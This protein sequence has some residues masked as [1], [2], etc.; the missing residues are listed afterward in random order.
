ME[1]TNVL[2]QKSGKTA[3]VVILLLVIAVGGFYYWWNNKIKDTNL[4]QQTGIGGEEDV[5]SLTPTLPEISFKKPMEVKT[6]EN[7][8]LSFSL[9]YESELGTLE[10]G[11]E[12][13]VY[14]KNSEATKDLA[15]GDIIVQPFLNKNS[16][17]Y[18]RHIASLIQQ[19]GVRHEYLFP[20]SDKNLGDI[21]N[22]EFIS[23]PNS[24][25]VVYFIYWKN[26]ALKT[27]YVTVHL[28][29]S[30]SEPKRQNE[31][32]AIINTIALK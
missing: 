1:Q 25:T 20:E 10:L 16:D 12:V 32:T 14:N 3:T 4:P 29:S 23:Y 24:N 6:F 19:G 26:K 5:I 13:E 2:N 15:G 18:E 17:V 8:K 22:V 9:Y 7:D 21:K 31:V 30:Y 28:S 11:S 27:N